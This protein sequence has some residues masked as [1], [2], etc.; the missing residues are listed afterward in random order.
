MKSINKYKK[1]EKVNF[2]PKKTFTAIGFVGPILTIVFSITLLLYW[3][4]PVVFGALELISSTN[5]CI[6]HVCCHRGGSNVTT[7]WMN[8]HVHIRQ[9]MCKFI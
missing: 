3:N 5:D 2:Y 4:T 6:N 1:I 9:H 8:T 7:V